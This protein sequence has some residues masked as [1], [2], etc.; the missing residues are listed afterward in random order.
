[1]QISRWNA[2]ARPLKIRPNKFAKGLTQTPTYQIPE[3]AILNFIDTVAP[4]QNQDGVSTAAAAAWAA[5]YCA[6]IINQGLR[7]AGWLT[8][9]KAT[10]ARC[11]TYLLT[12]QYGSATGISPGGSATNPR[13]GGILVS[14]T[15]D[16]ATTIAAGLAFTKAYQA[17][18]SPVYIQAADHCATFMRHVQ[19]GDLQVSAWTVFPSGGGPY[20]I[21]GLA[22][23]VTDST[24]L[25]TTSYLLQD[26]AA[27]WF[28]NEF[29]TIQGSATVYG[30]LAS[31]AFFS[32]PTSATLA[33]MISEL[34]TFAGTG[35]KDSAATPV[36]ANV[37][38]LSATAP[39]AT[40]VAATNG[41]AG[42][43]TWTAISTIASEAIALAALGVFK[44]SGMNGQ[45][46]TIMAWLASF[47]A[48]PANATPIQ[49]EHVTIAGI[50]GT[51]N[52][53]LCPADNLTT[54]APFTEAAGALYSWSSLGI[55]S[56]ILS[57]LS[58]GLRV[59][60]DTLSA[61]V[62][63]DVIHYDWKYMGPLGLSGLSLQPGTRASDVVKAAKAAM[64]Y[65]QPP[66][67]YPQV[68]LF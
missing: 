24:G 10:L 53:A 37:T 68:G 34:G 50:T 61:P 12:Q 9:A 55:L 1:M 5:I 16:T 4:S 32:A 30:D 66:G 54:S 15:Y 31:T 58:P 29:A 14:G 21:G 56:P 52:P 59:S 60:K 65:R 62:R 49:P 7:P 22:S 40:Y 44:V 36:G 64:V 38:G 11:L 35:P 46:T 41:G 45:L 47:T 39:R 19:C 2:R 26:V 67:Y 3:A 33:T 6:D 17:T 43:G 42:T 20:H 23:G 51:Y 25:L 13:Y 28:L 48:N 18:G 57:T 8:T 63:T 27:M